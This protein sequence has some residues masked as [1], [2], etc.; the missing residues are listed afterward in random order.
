MAVAVAPVHLLLPHRPKR[1]PRAARR[2]D[3]AAARSHP[4]PHPRHLLQRR[5]P[6]LREAPPTHLTH[7]MCPHHLQRVRFLLHSPAPHAVRS[8]EATT[9][10]QAT[11]LQTL[12]T[13]ASGK[14]LADEAN[15]HRKAR[16]SRSHV[17]GPPAQ[18]RHVPGRRLAAVLLVREAAAVASRRARGVMYSARACPVVA[19]MPLGRVVACLRRPNLLEATPALRP[20]TARGVCRHTCYRHRR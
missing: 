5:R 11:T 18:A 6:H 3:A 1:P 19:A 4:P 7:R 17:V 9:L 12:T 14:C 16:H 15:R 10:P 20:C 13:Q 2:S 8:Q